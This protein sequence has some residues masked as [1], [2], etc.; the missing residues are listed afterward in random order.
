LKFFK[1]FLLGPFGNFFKFRKFVGI[2]L[3]Q[4]MVFP[5]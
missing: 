5:G 3:P 1:Q 2:Y 4:Q